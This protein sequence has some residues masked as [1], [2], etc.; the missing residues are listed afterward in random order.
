MEPTPRQKQI[1]SLCAAGLHAREIAQQL[2]ITEMT[3]AETLKQSRQRVGARSTINLVA[4]SL[5]RGWIRPLV[6]LL[7]VVSIT[8]YH[9]TELR[10]R[11]APRN[12]RMVLVAKRRSCSR[13][14]PVAVVACQEVAA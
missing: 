1:I 9:G 10:V 11:S 14:S 4:M 12:P 2:H 5:S 3:V 6:V 8:E 7:V 13:N